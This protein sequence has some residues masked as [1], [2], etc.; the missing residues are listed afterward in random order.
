MAKNCILLK[1][2]LKNILLKNIIYRY[3]NELN[4]IGV[5]F[6]KFYKKIEK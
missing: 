4:F 6:F 1:P 3:I 5:N 2:R